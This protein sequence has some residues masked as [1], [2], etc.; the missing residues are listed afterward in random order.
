VI[1]EVDRGLKALI[2]RIDDQERKIAQVMRGVGAV[3][4]RE[5]AAF[6]PKRP[7]LAGAT[8]QNV[9]D[10]NYLGFTS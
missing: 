6:V 8:E 5:R 3:I 4:Q 10:Q 2:E 9:L 7:L 1:S